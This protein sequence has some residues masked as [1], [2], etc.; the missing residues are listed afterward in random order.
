MRNLELPEGILRIDLSLRNLSHTDNVRDFRCNLSTV[1]FEEL[2]YHHSA[3]SSA[4]EGV[5][6]RRGTNIS[7]T[8]LQAAR[9]IADLKCFTH[10]LTSQY[11][12]YDSPPLTARR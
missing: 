1:N 7:P 6:R 3:A 4:E 2:L 9:H 10:V 5:G 12:A 11:L 8:P